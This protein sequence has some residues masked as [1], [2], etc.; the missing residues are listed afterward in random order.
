MSL[1][2]GSRANLTKDSAT[3]CQEDK[4]IPT[5]QETHDLLWV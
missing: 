2:D 3:L 5:L 1:G 4:S